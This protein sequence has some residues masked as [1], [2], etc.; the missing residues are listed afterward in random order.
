MSKVKRLDL[1]WWTDT[2]RGMS[3]IDDGKYVLYE[4]YDKLRA[5]LDAA[6]K[7]LARVDNWCSQN[8]ARHLDLDDWRELDRI[9]KS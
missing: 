1:E 6:L 8:I 3:V 7:K 2:E 9:L 4:D 5:E